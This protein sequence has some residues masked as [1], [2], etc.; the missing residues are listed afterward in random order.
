MV[1]PSIQDFFC[2]LLNACDTSLNLCTKYKL[3]ILDYLKFTE[4]GDYLSQVLIKKKRLD[5]VTQSSY[6]QTKE[7]LS[8]KKKIGNACK[9]VIN[10]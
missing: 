4:F 5:Q 2:K 9:M 8:K 1:H 3:K 6:C 7:F 10:K